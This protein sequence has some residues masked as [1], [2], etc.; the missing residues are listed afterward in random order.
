MPLVP[1]RP[2][3]LNVFLNDPIVCDCCDRLHVHHD[4]LENFAR[5]RCEQ[6]LSLRGVRSVGVFHVHS[7]GRQ[8]HGK[9]VLLQGLLDGFPVLALHIA[10]R[11]GT[12][13]LE[14]DVN[15]LI[16][17]CVK[18]A[19]QINVFHFIPVYA[20]IRLLVNV[21]EIIAQ[22]LLLDC[23]IA[24]FRHRKSYVCPFLL[25]NPIHPTSRNTYILERLVTI[26]GSIT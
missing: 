2:L 14:R 11:L 22:G 26:L 16:N 25:N 1:D 20:V 13:H 23:S 18:S 5:N 12:A 4:F 24:A 7:V 19:L 9:I 10:L 17:L 21:A 15:E 6:I 3:L 8:L